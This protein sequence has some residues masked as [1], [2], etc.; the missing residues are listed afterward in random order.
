MIRMLIVGYCFGIRLRAAALRGGSHEPVVSLV[1]QARPHRPPLKPPTKQL[2]LSFRASAAPDT[3][4]P[5]ER[6]ILRQQGEPHLAG[7]LF[8]AWP[9]GGF[10]IE[11]RSVPW[12]FREIQLRMRRSN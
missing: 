1:L 10:P 11:N 2:F 12:P 7:E 4:A 3:S 6:Q 8:F 5:G 9:H